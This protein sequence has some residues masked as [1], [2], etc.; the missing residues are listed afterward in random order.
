M[1]LDIVGDLFTHRRQLKHLDFD[2]R[3]V[4]LLGKLPI[5]GCLVPEIVRPV[6]VVSL[7]QRS[8]PSTAPNVTK[9]QHV[10]AAIPHVQWLLFG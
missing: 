6:H 1:I 10:E 8:E 3:I 9:G 4:S 2:E 5:L 7:A